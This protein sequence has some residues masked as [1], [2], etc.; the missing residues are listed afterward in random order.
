MFRFTLRRL[1]QA[2]PT[3]LGVS[4][5]AY[6]LMS[7][8]PGGPV[9]AMTGGQKL[10][11]EARLAV[12]ARL[13]VN[14]PIWL[15]YLRWLIGD[16]WL[17]W[18][19]NGDDIADQAFLVPLDADGDG[20]PEPPGERY[21]VLRGDWGDSFYSKKPVVQVFGERIP[22]TF[23]L[24]IISLV[25]GTLIGVTVG[26]LSAVLRGGLFDNVARI[27]AV[28]FSA[29]P[30]FWLG[31][32]MIMIFGVALQN[33]PEPFNQ[34]ALPMGGRCKISIAGGCPPLFQR[35]EYLLMPAFVL[36]T[37]AIAVYSRFVRASMLDIISQDY[38]RTAKAKGL[39][40]RMVWFKHAARNALI[41]VATFLGPSITGVLSGA[42]LTET[43][44]SWPGIGREAVSSVF[45]FD[46]PMVMAVA[47][48]G[49]VATI[50]G[51]ILSDIMYAWID[52]RVRLD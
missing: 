19:T 20:E 40:G 48:F 46:Y 12:A 7:A 35:L 44:F 36:S 9:A 13:G 18:D 3:L 2:I 17:R 28:I 24:G 45:R 37:G 22:A 21:G 39:T 23:E 29:V 15:Q 4:V 50:L 52:P 31:L 14:D 26:I 34:L 49:A 43:I 5:L 6:L 27:V 51:F 16:D 30:I 33:A 42:V 32:L 10:T 41:P 8:A 47:M 1:L 11:A 38:I 25:V